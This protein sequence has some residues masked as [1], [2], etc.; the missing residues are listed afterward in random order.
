MTEETTQLE[1]KT[2]YLAKSLPQSMYNLVP[3][4]FQESMDRVDESYFIMSE[5]DLVK[6]VKPDR[7]LNCLRYRLWDEYNRAL[8]KKYPHLSMPNLCAGICTESYLR[9]AVF[10][11]PVMVAWLLT[12]PKSYETAAEE[13]LNHG[14]EQLR[15]MLDFPIYDDKGRPDL[16]SAKLQLEIVKM[17]DARLKGAPLQ[18]LAVEQKNLNINATAKEAREI[19]ENM[20]MEEIEKRLAK[21]RGDDEKHQIILE[22]RPKLE[23][24]KSRAILAEPAPRKAKPKEF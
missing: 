4:K 20:G 5:E 8:D 3:K 2:D 14:I 15:K 1:T 19:I 21:L 7:T 12:P 13:A 18:R 10:R 9:L 23:E 24:F 6:K 17:I 16:K 11:N 22:A